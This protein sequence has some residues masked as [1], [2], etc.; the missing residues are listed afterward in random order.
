MSV[1]CVQQE[2]SRGFGFL[3]FPTLEKSKTF[4]EQNFP[5]IYLYGKGKADN[6]D[7][8]AKVRIAF[9][10]ERDERSR[11]EKAEGEW[12]CKIVNSQIVYASNTLLTL[13]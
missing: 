2:V 9:S 6:D 10:R 3:R 11:M 8:V 7:Q 4:L 5:M 1:N 13:H 12:T